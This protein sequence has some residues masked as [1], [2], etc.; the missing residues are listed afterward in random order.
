MHK[1]M[2][3]NPMTSHGGGA[4]LIYSDIFLYLQTTK[5]LVKKRCAT[6]TEQRLSVSRATEQLTMRHT[7]ECLRSSCQK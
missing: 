7:K 6:V 5:V 1:I 4:T 2:L 3:K